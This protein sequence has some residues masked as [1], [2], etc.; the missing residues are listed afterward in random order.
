[1]RRF[2][3]AFRTK[4]PG[5]L[6]KGLAITVDAVYAAKRH[7]RVPK[8]WYYAAM[9]AGISADWLLSG[10]GPMRFGEETRGDQAGYQVHAAGFS[11]DDDVRFLIRLIDI[12][13]YILTFGGQKPIKEPQQLALIAGLFYKSFFNAPNRVEILEQFREGTIEGLI[14]FIS[15]P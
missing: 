2:Y 3:T 7:Q 15:E 14:K 1:M 4:S 12:V 8:K 5:E 6:A 13:F 11:M 9:Q 10:K